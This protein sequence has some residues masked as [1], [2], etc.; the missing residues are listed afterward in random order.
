[1]RVR[2]L[3]QGGLDERRQPT[4]LPARASPRDK[5][6]REGRE[7]NPSVHGAGVQRKLGV[8]SCGPDAQRGHKV[9]VA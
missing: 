2:R 4:N 7:T 9:V 8:A 6:L 5:R 1:M 3:G